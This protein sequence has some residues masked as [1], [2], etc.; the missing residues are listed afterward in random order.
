MKEEDLKKIQYPVVVKPVDKS[1]NRGVNYC[2]NESELRDAYKYAR[3]LSDNEVVVCERQLHGPE[4]VVNYIIENGEARLLYFGRELHQHGFA[5]NNYSM[6]TTSSNGL[7]QWNKEVDASIKAL[8]K[9]VGFDNGVVWFETIRDDDGKFYLIEPGYR[10]SSE[11]LYSLYEKVNGFNTTKWFIECA[12]GIKHDFS[13]LP[14]QLTEY[15]PQC[16]GGYHL[17]AC[18]GGIIAKIE[19]LD[20]LEKMENVVIDLPKREGGKVINKVCMG[21]IKIYGNTVEELVDTLQKI[22]SVFFMRDD[23]GENMFIRYTDYQDLLDDF[24]L[25]RKSFR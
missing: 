15:H 25:G 13:K 19:G 3:E 17:F 4:W 9:S 1:G 2:T 16:V 14:V 23:A 18:R 12:L 7:R 11:S 5:A 6:I 22:N 10:F 20:V 21:L 24:I 8:F